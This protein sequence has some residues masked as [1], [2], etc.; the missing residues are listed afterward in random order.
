MTNASR[1]NLERAVQQSGVA[2]DLAIFES[3]I[4]TI[5][6]CIHRRARG[7]PRAASVWAISFS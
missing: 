6:L 5:P 3:S 4:S 2:P 7:F 1:P